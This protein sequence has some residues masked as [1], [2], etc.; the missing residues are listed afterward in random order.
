MLRV[1]LVVSMTVALLPL[2][3]G[4]AKN[5][6]LFLADAGGIPVISAASL[7]GY[8]AP[9]RLFIQRMPNIGLSDTSPTDSFVSDSAAGMTAIVTGQKTKNGVIAQSAEAQRKVT[10]GKPLKTILEYAEERGMSTGIITNDAVTGAT[11]ATL[12][13]KVNER[14]MTSA[15]YQQ[16]FTP[17]FGDGPDVIIGPGRAAIA[18]A[19]IADKIDIDQL[20]T[21]QGPAGLEVAR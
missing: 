12:Y 4:P 15:I 6:V 20:S 8:G 2:P 11:P 3:Q 16:I 5:V 1:V 18:K 9:R 14:G 10:D 17:R 13:A 21:G 7:H 19:L